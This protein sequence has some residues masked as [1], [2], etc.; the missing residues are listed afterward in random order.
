MKTRSTWLS[1]T[2]EVGTV[3]HEGREYT[4]MGSMVDATNGRAVA[5]VGAVCAR[6][7]YGRPVHKLTAWDGCQLGT[8][9][10]VSRWRTPRSFLSSHMV[11]YRVD[12]NGQRWHGRGCGE[13]MVLKLKRCKVR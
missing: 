9:V 10:E 11:S 13:G 6:D 1:A 7:A 3:E 5:Y 8:A 2:V 4:A 12:M